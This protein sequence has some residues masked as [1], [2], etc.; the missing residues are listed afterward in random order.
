M[1]TS[2]IYKKIREV[3]PPL[4]SDRVLYDDI[5]KILQ[6]VK[7]DSILNAVEKKVKLT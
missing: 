4:N 7:N 1:G 2:I 3:I 6:V 5:K